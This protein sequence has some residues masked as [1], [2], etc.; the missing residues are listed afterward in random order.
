M[1]GEVQEAIKDDRIA[2]KLL[3]HSAS[4]LAAFLQ[5]QARA[6]EAKRIEEEAKAAEEVR[7]AEERRRS[8]DASKTGR[9]ALSL[10]SCFSAGVPGK[11]F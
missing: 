2:V 9:T 7:V 1:M 5:V 8:S 3:S 11:Y 6:A 10:H 4:A